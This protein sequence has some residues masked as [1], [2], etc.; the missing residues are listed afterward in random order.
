MDAHTQLLDDQRRQAVS[1]A[2][3]SEQDALALLRL[4]CAEAGMLGRSH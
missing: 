3:D 1:C 2:P 4:S